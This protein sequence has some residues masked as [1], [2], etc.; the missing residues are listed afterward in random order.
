MTG[1][2]IGQPLVV[3][4]SADGYHDRRIFLNSLYDQQ[5]IYLLPS[6][7][8]VVQPTYVL[9][10]FSGYYSQENSVLIIQREINGSYQTV[11][12]DYF[13]ATGGFEAT[14]EE[15]V[16]H[17]LVI[18]NTKTGRSRVLGTTMAT[19]DAEKLIRV[20]NDEEIELVDEGD[21]SP[22]V[23]PTLSTLPASTT[24]ISITTYANDSQT[25]DI[26]ITYQNDSV[27][28][29]LTTGSIGGNTEEAF[30]IDLSDRSKGSVWVNIS[31]TTVDGNSATKT[32][33]I[34][35]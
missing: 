13:G 18:M 17:R 28:D 6:S 10:D 2:P 26:T 34:Q 35:R 33:R 31:W 7:E 25:Y 15:G 30:N 9:E 24:E 32:R 12:G 23:G 11:V 22:T 19:D 16:R 1:L 4:A 14:L 21:R 3:V 8:P 20:L 27:T 5:E 29:T